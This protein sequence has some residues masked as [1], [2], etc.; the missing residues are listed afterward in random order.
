LKIKIVFL[1]G[2]R[3][4]QCL[5]PN[6]FQSI[7]LSIVA[8]FVIL[9]AAVHGDWKDELGVSVTEIVGSCGLR[10]AR[11]TRTGDLHDMVIAAA[12]GVHL[13]FVYERD[14]DCWRRACTCD[15]PTVP[16]TVRPYTDVVV[17]RQM[18]H[19]S[20]NA[21]D[22]STGKT[23]T[24][25]YNGSY[26]LY[27]FEDVCVPKKGGPASASTCLSDVIQTGVWCSASVWSRAKNC[28]LTRYCVN[29]NGSA[30]CTHEF[31]DWVDEPA[32]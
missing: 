17:P 11:L 20:L 9:V 1:N 23:I 28:A 18:A 4:K 2:P 26:E 19:V 31:V 24:T 27:A 13:G 10:A 6:A 7:M 30:Q 32:A 12:R 22:P 15:V 21:L 3:F 29:N 25:P 8:C 5:N 14:K 16:P